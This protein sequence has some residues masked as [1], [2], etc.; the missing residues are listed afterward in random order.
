MTIYDLRLGAFAMYSFMLGLLVAKLPETRSWMTLVL[1]GVC[2]GWGTWRGLV[3]W[4]WLRIA[5]RRPGEPVNGTKG[6]PR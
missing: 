5:G 1:G 2:V 4:E 3:I 6:G